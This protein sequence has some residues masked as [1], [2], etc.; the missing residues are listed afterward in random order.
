M[1]CQGEIRVDT[2]VQSIGSSQRHVFECLST[3]ARRTV[4]RMKSLM[5]NIAKKV[6]SDI[7]QADS[8]GFY[9]FVSIYVHGI[10]SNVSTKRRL[11]HLY[12]AD[13]ELPIHRT[14]EDIQRNLIDSLIP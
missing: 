8:K 5:E 3:I 13:L 4:G 9:L 14:Y 7:P 6:R 10:T 12:Y 1:V 2:I 11:A